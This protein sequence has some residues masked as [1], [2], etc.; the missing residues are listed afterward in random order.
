MQRKCEVIQHMKKLIIVSNRLPVTVEKKKE[1]I[2]FTK[3]VGG[4]ATGLGSLYHKYNSIWIGWCGL[5]AEK[6]DHQEKQEIE[7]I[8]LKDHNSYSTF[9][10][11]QD[12]K[13]YYQGFCNKTIW[14]LFHYF[15]ECAVYDQTLW[16]SYQHV[17]RIFCHTVMKIIK[18]GDVLWIHDYQLMLLPKMIRKKIP[19]VTIGFFLHIPF[20]S[21]EVFR[22]LP[23]RREVLEGLL[24]ADLVGFH[25]F[26]YVRHF[27]SSV[28][29]ILGCEQT[30][31]QVTVDTRSVK[32]DAFPMGIDFEKFK[33]ASK[34]PEVI[35]EMKS[36]RKRIHDRKIIL[37]VDRMDY[38]KGILHRL[39]AFDL[40]LKKYPE[41]KKR[42]ML[43]LVAVPSRTGVE[44]YIQLKQQ[45]D[46]LVGGINGRHGS[47]DWTPIQYFYR[48][49]PFP[50]L[51][52]FYHVAD[53]A[54]VTPLRDGMNLIAKEYVAAKSCSPGVLVLSE[55][56]GAASEMSGAIIVNPNIR[57]QVAEGIHKALTMPESEQKK[58]NQSMQHRLKRYDV[59]KWAN[60][61]ME[62]L[63]YIKT[64]QESLVGKKITR[65]IQ[66]QIR[67]KYL[68]AK[69]R[70][71]FL[72][73]DGT[74]VSFAS[75]PEGARPDKGILGILHS[76]A[77]DF[78]NDLILISGRE[79][80]TL[81]KWFGKLNIGLIAEH[82][83]WLKPRGK[84]WSTI[85]PLRQDWKRKIK[86]LLEH[87]V[88]RTPGS[89]LE[90]KDYSLVWH[91]RQ[92]DQ[93]L[94]QVR[95]QE[96]K[97]AFLQ[98][99]ENLNLEI[100]DGNKVLEIKSTGVNKGVAALRWIRN[101]KW[102]FILAIG[103]DV[104]D[105]NIFSVLPDWACSVKVGLQP[106]LASFS[107]ESVRD[108]RFFLK[109][110]N[111]GG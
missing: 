10:S 73:Y 89:L 39:E 66:E 40:F 53:V 106:S 25:T 93:D 80:K 36:I 96:L 28:R 35:K 16:E 49:F 50:T 104:T 88:D 68:K 18:P 26:D 37:S 4:L 77:I 52:A 19:D 79:R 97:D 45:V 48:S 90:E 21:F 14:P 99:A 102:D 70:L 60:D 62:R 57:E 78:K 71:I 107:L 22:L 2:L 86:P 47:I 5:S 56:A 83:V 103:D 61:F 20:P 72:D 63:D 91:Y 31:G 59:L 33:S 15:T 24:G 13:M 44:T 42:V 12:V 101:K 74:L 17:N 34:M 98:M 29:R 30:V 9:L 85:G 7:D 64:M 46:E 11:R 3:S 76:L 54:L 58:R 51:S 8:L 41:Y 65:D 67:W 94:A 43:I 75:T 87:Y 82:G 23:W 111:K 84:E 81:D 100:M 55:T 27:L 1:S 69:N 95:V 38:T 109:Y 32:I 105:E 6:L 92:T 108:V 110:L